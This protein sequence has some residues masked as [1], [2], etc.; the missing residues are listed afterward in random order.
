MDFPRAVCLVEDEYNY[1]RENYPP[2]ESLFDAISAIETQM[3][4]LRF[5]VYRGSIEQVERELKQVAST[6]IRAMVEVC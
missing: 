2:F 5:R 4:H 6:C 1:A 3:A